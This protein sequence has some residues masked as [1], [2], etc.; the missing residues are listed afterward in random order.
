MPPSSAAM[1]FSSTSVRRVHDARVDVALQTEVEQVGAVLRV[2]EGVG[3]R[4]V[5]RDGHGLG[6]RVLSFLVM[7]MKC[8]E[9]K[10]VVVLR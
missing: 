10:C 4:L 6:G 9:Q 7:T 5:D 8:G 3:G 2:V 1:R